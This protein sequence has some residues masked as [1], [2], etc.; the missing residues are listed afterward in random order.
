MWLN[1][2]SKNYLNLFFHQC[3]LVKH[4]YGQSLIHRFEKKNR[5]CM[6]LKILNQTNAQMKRLKLLQLKIY[7]NN[8]YLLGFATGGKPQP[9]LF[10]KTWKNS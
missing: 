3:L 10:L 9:S 7:L 1:L 8:R 4:N 5:I 2:T 6:W